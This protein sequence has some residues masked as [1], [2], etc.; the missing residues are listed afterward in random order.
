MDREIEERLERALSGYRR[1]REQF[2]ATQKNLRVASATSTSRDRL[3]TVTVDVRGNVTALKFNSADYAALDETELAD[4]I[5]TTMTE[6]R[7]KIRGQAGPAVVP[8]LPG[9]ARC[10]EVAGGSPRMYRLLPREPARRGNGR[11]TLVLVMDA[12]EGACGDE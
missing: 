12:T 2:L 4:L 8:L 7:A 1:K 10:D 11:A 3:V 5:M 6:A 9:S